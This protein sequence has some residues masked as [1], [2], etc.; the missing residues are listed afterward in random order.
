MPPEMAMR[1]HHAEQLLAEA[2][3]AKSSGDLKTAETKLREC[4]KL[5]TLYSVDARKELGPVY[6]REGKLVKAIQ[7]YQEL[8][9]PTDGN[10]GTFE[11]DGWANTRLAFVLNKAG[12]WPEAVH[13]YGE[14]LKNTSMLNDDQHG[15][16]NEPPISI[17]F[18]PTRPQP[19]A[20]AAALHML[21]GRRNGRLYCKEALPEFD[22]ALKIEPNLAIA[23]YYRGYCLREQGHFADASASFKQA[24]DLGHDEVKA[25]AQRALDG[26]RARI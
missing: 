5:E 14:A 18:N 1:Y 19:K 21:A 15:S 2:K 11:R 26:L 4:I 9:H 13:E 23:Y 17:H 12:C 20:L 6:E 8:L 22:E 3:R 10:G 16:P 7:V 25:A 24:R